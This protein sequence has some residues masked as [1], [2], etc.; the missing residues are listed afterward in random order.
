[1]KSFMDFAFAFTCA[2]CGWVICGWISVAILNQIFTL[3]SEIGA[4]ILCLVLSLDVPTY[5]FFKLYK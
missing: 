3:K 5:I 2:M 1:M 4:F